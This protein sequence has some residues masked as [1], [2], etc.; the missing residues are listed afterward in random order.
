VTDLAES[1]QV[2]VSTSP[3]FTTFLTGYNG[4]VT[5]QNNITVDNLSPG[6]TYYFR[7]KSLSAATESPYS[8]TVTILTSP[9]PPVASGV[10]A[11]TSSGFTAEWQ[12]V[13]TAI[14]Y[15]VDVSKDNF[16]TFEEGY[17]GKEITGTSVEITGLTAGITYKFRV[18]AFNGTTSV[19]SNEIS[20]ITKPQAPADGEATNITQTSF[21][22]TWDAVV[23]ADSYNIDVSDDD[24][25]S[26]IFGYQSKNFTATSAE[27]TDLDPGRSYALR[28]RAVNVS[29]ESANSV[30]IT[31]ITV[32]GTPGL[33]VPNTNRQ[34]GFDLSWSA[35]EGA[36]KYLLDVSTTENF[37]V[38]VTGYP[39]EITGTSASLS[40]L[41]S[42]VKYFARLRSANGS[43]ASDNSNVVSQTTLP[44]TPVALSVDPNDLTNTSFK[45]RWNAAQ[46]ATGYELEVTGN[47]FVEFVSGYGPKVISNAT[48]EIVTGLVPKTAYKFRLRAKSQDGYSSYSNIISVQT[49]DEAIAPLQINTLAGSST[50]ESAFETLNITVNVSGGVPPYAVDMRHRVV[51]GN[52]FEPVP[53]TPKSANEYEVA[54]EQSYLDEIGMEYFFE[55][56]DQAGSKA[57]QIEHSFLYRLI[58][59]ASPDASIPFESNFD[60]KTNSYQMF[61]IPYDLDDKTFAGIFNELG[62]Y[63]KKKWRLFHYDGLSEKY[64]EYQAGLSNVVELGKGY[65]F[66]AARMRYCSERRSTVE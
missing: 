37:A 4:L 51:T 17:N 54:V 13:V 10:S 23:G 66:N 11:I 27:V 33:N 43:G 31:V 29:G 61:S 16:A 62:A 14:K 22:V 38:L 12:P 59:A 26:L 50:V 56:T 20:T 28:I 8:N 24:F 5:S 9:S 3:D 39:K 6:Q 55:V 42:G 32:P 63:D 40:G 65:W 7:I 34:D 18:K 49:R 47:D 25:A 57:S 15:L 45:A 44:A 36:E 52:D 21:L 41:A 2:D 58:T 30:A 64:V 19:Y 35:I 1:Y 46:G 53:A 48:E 60:G